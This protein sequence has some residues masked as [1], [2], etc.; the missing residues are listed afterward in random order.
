MALNLSNTL[1]ELLGS[2]RTNS[3]QSFRFRNKMSSEKLEQSLI[4]LVKSLD[5][6]A[7]SLHTF[8][9]LEVTPE[10]DTIHFAIRKMPGNQSIGWIERVV[11]LKTGKIETVSGPLISLNLDLEFQPMLNKHLGFERT[12]L[13]PLK[14]IAS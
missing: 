11:I 3:V 4:E 9:C 5:A 7:T 6:E 13:V 14:N 8:F 1:K 2:I 10:I 12:N